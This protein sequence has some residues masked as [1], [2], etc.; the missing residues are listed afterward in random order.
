MVNYVYYFFSCRHC[1]DNFRKKVNRLGFL[2][3]NPR[4]SI[5][6]LWQIHNM[7]NAKLKGDPTEDPQHP[8]I[9]WPSTTDCPNCR[10]D[11]MDLFNLD[12][13]IAFV[14]GQLWNITSLVEHS[15]KVY[16]ADLLVLTTPRKDETMNNIAPQRLLAVKNDQELNAAEREKISQTIVEMERV[17]QSLKRIENETSPS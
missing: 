16:G 11:R 5:L 10:T 6:W 12:P 4:D 15:I 17:L 13:Q 14:E 7:A 3:V 8:K 1:A 2:P 9:I